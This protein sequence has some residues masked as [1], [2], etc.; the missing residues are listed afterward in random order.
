MIFPM[1]KIKLYTYCVLGKRDN[2]DKILIGFHEHDFVAYVTAGGN[3]I[4]FITVK[5]RM[6]KAEA[7]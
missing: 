4:I 7:K 1:F 3:S 5:W 2:E 6:E